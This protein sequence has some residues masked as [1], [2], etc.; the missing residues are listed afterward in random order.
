MGATLGEMNSHPPPLLQNTTQNQSKP[1]TPDPK[2]QTQKPQTSNLQ[3]PGS[4]DVNL[5]S[6][7]RDAYLLERALRCGVFGLVFG[8]WGLR[9]GV[10]GLG[11]GVWGLGFK[12][13]GLGLVITGV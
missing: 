7:T 5:F 12:V 11:F 13:W 6:M 4:D 9:F 1:Q 10:W 3:H 2:P 8:V